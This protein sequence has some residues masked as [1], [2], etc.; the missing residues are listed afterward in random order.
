[1]SN[2]DPAVRMSEEQEMQEEGTAERR[3]RLLRFGLILLPIL[4]F[5][6]VAGLWVVGSVGQELGTAIFHGA[7]WAAGAGVLSVVVYM[8]YKS[9]VLKL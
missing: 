6:I 8:V 4:A 2:I 9:M 1:M 7:I 5:A 3:L